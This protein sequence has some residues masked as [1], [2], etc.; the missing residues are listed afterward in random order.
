[1]KT[2]KKPIYPIL[3]SVLTAA[4]EIDD[5]ISKGRIFFRDEV[6]FGNALARVYR[7]PP[8]FTEKDEFEVDHLRI[9]KI[10]DKVKDGYLLPIEICELLDASGIKRAGEAVVTSSNDAVNQAKLLGFPI[11]MKVVGPIHKSDVGGVVLNVKD[12]NEVRR[13][14]D[15]MICIKD[16]TAILIQPMLSGTELFV[17]AKYEPKFGHV[18]LCGLG[19]IFIEV[20]KD[21]ASGLVPISGEE[22]LFMIH[23]LKSY[24]IIKGVRG[25]KGVNEELFA[26]VI[27]RLSALLK[28]APEII[29]LDFNPL[30]GKEDSVVVVDARIRLKK[31]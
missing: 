18:V 27:L 16:T 6:V 13:E 1:M 19:G 25:Q 30:L 15:R 26:E 3:P 12:E 5:F 22:A 23:N 21:V 7:I 29:E 28:A 8:P 2:A 4:P 11:V 24:K 14:F 9:R 17:G 10:V 31:N 20:L